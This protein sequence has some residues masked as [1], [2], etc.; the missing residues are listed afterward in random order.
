MGSRVR[1]IKPVIGGQL[2]AVNKRL[3]ARRKKTDAVGIKRLRLRLR[4]PLFWFFLNL[5]LNHKVD[6]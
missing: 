1:K 3:K 2:S 5:S 4:N 6:A